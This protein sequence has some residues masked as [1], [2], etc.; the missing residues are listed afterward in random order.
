[1]IKKN[2]ADALNQQIQHEQNNAQRYQAVALYFEGLNLHGLAACLNKQVSDERGHADKFIKH[3]VD[4]GG[5]TNQPTRYYRIE[6][7][8]P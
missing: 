2:I 6:V 7:I 3:M 5:A 1:M 4:R 8:A